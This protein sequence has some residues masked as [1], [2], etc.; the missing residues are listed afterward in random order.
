MAAR[1]L[2]SLGEPEPDPPLGDE[3]SGS[4]APVHV[5]EGVLGGYVERVG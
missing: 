2:V 4:M 3:A 1:R 5:L